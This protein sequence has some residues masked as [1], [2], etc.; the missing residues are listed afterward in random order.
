MADHP[1]MPG[2]SCQALGVHSGYVVAN[3]IAIDQRDCVIFN[4]TCRPHEFTCTHL[5]H[6]TENQFAASIGLLGTDEPFC[7]KPKEC[8]ITRSKSFNLTWWSP[9][10]PADWND[11]VHENLPFLFDEFGEIGNSPAFN[12]PSL[13][14]PL[15][16]VTEWKDILGQ[17]AISRQAN[18]DDI[19]L[20]VLGTF[21]YT[22]E[23]MY[24]VLVCIKG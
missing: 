24:A 1:V 21:L 15:G 11:V 14:G 23:I 22:K 17:Y 9:F 6:Y 18:V 4:E 7:F 2:V 20:R 16:F 10:P 8:S 19:E 12:G 3:P 5:V 13:C